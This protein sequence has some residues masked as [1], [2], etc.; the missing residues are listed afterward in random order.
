[1][2]SLPGILSLLLLSCFTGVSAEESK[3]APA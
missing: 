1:M 2:R 3:A